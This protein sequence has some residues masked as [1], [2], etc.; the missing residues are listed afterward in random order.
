MN[1]N[2]L[3]E[4][5]RIALALKSGLTK[6]QQS[7]KLYLMSI[8]IT[9]N[10]NLSKPN[11][12]PQTRHILKEKIPDTD[13]WTGLAPEKCPGFDP[14]RQCLVALPQLNLQTC[15]RQQVLDYFNNNWTL[16]ELL[17]R[18][19]KN[20]EA[21]IR[22]PYH[23]LRHPMIFYYG[24][25]AVLFVNKL[26]LAGVFK[27]PINL[28]LEKV[29]ETGVDEM[30]W[31]DLSKNEM[32]WPSV[33]EVKNY[34][35]QVYDLVLNL[36]QTHPD[37]ASPDESLAG[38]SENSRRS[39]TRD[40]RTSRNLL[41]D[42]PLWALWMGFEHEKIHFETSSVLIRELPIDYVET[43]KYWAPIFSDKNKSHLTT[44]AT[45]TSTAGTSQT[46]TTKDLTWKT[47]KGSVV[48]IGKPASTPYYGWDNEYGFRETKIQD[49][50]YTEK[51]ISNREYFEFVSQGHY[52]LDEY[53]SAE[54]LQWRK[55][56]N[57]KRPTFWA[58]VGPEGSHEY[59]LRTIFEYIPMPW[60]WP[61]E[62][63]F[64]EA[65]AY[66]R[67]R[68]K[69][70]Q[71]KLH[72]RLLT[73]AEYRSV[74]STADRLAKYADA[75]INFK[76]SSASP[77]DDSWNGNV[78]QWMEDQF[79]PLPGFQTHRLY[80]D[81][82][83]P[84]FDGKHQMILGGSFISCGHEASPWARFH[85]RPHF[86][87]HSGF[88]MA[89]TLDG[90]L[91]N[92]AVKLQTSTEYIHPSRENI[93]DQT[94]K[95]NWWNTSLYQPLEMNLPEMQNLFKI[96][97]DKIMQFEKDYA[98]LPPMGTAL[99]PFT[100]DLKKDFHLPYQSTKD[101]PQRAESAEKLMDLIFKELAPYGQWP[102][103]PGYAAYV[104][105]SGNMISNV[106][107][108]MAQTLNPFS[109]HYN[110]S[111]GLVALELEAL[112]WFKNLFGFSSQ[113]GAYFTS[114]SSV[115]GMSA[116]SMARNQKLRVS[117][118]NYDLSKYTLYL[119]KQAH[120]CSAKSWVFLGFNPENIRW[121]EVD[122]KTLSMK[123]SA[124]SEQ[125]AIDKKSNLIPLCVVGTAGTT[126][127]GAIDPLAAI[128]N[129]CE[130]EKIWFHVDGAYGAAF[131]LTESGK[132]KLVGI[133]KADSLAFDLHKSLALPYG[134]GCLIIKNPQSM[135]FSDS[136][137]KTYMPPR[138]HPQMGVEKEMGPMD[139][140]DVTP[141]LSRDYRGL[142]V[143]LPIKMLGI[144]PFILNLEEKLELSKWLH[145]QLQSK[146]KLQVLPDPQL[147]II[148]F[149]VRE[150]N[151]F[152]ANDANAANANT[153]AI[154]KANAKTQKLLGRINEKGTLF[155]SSCEVNGRKVIR[156]CLLGY[157]LHHPR[158]QQFLQELDLIL[159]EL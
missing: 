89:A 149:S 127:T 1:S 22:P 40:T 46:E 157:R 37:L 126:N 43:P 109:G 122:E 100:N 81:F 114:G 134:T 35:K 138:Y 17:F 55:F 63:N 33:I 71:S 118:P 93:L 56:R 105:G 159:G 66:C 25:P 21:Y 146:T 82:S 41:A 4:Q 84:C 64:H 48:Q 36:I 101:F 110:M 87:Q 95:P 135:Y 132:N 51:L 147:S 26:R 27:A 39:Q 65:Q 53:W 139:F 30:S 16:T 90:S 96:M 136:G 44:T 103:H 78:W 83:T 58:A 104:A 117:A 148:G 115:A 152:R 106:G 74:L 29:L 19:L 59:E 128:A 68:N 18:G 108:L 150:E 144:Q 2:S 86:Y 77:V 129:I 116:L 57:T 98:Q 155:L 130:T 34:R 97:T 137:S 45:G 42:S 20:E 9:R 107:Q 153:N 75:N 47:Q 91:D 145:Q 143:W 49:F 151:S 13:W 102:G 92:G 123:I 85:F 28:Y 50:Q 60:D 158:L 79:N 10:P 72:Y 73:E 6:C 52:V 131:I 125:I 70:D 133:E 120:H 121:I 142:R 140:A 11:P 69:K 38:G 14:V 3:V 99:D 31:D 54:G 119:S 154:D 111:P 62:V 113:A 67:W 8:T 24:H 15:T 94:Q 156:I 76:Y 32:T 12:L 124:L 112:G 7:S 88:R 5:K 80:D 23:Q 141:E 61:A